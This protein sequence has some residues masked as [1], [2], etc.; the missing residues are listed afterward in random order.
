MTLNFLFEDDYGQ[1]IELTFID[2]DTDAA[3]DISGYGT[4]IQMLFTESDGTATAK[5]ATFKTDGSDGII[6]YT[7]DSSFLT[8]GDWD[9]RGK[10]T[11]GAAQLQTQK[12][13]F[14]VHA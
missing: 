2:I 9:V 6:T 1:P 8:E 13:S 11:A 7:I 3:A 14:K 12:H 5:T 10:V 4:S